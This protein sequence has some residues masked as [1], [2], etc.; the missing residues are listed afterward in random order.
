VT[1]PTHGIKEAIFIWFD[2]RSAP[3][4]GGVSSLF[5]EAARNFASDSG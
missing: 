4:D 1:K 5:P 3:D 2:H